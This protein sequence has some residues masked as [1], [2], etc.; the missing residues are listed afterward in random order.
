MEKLITKFE[1]INFYKNKLKPNTKLLVNLQLCKAIVEKYKGSDGSIFF[2]QDLEDDDTPI[3]QHDLLLITDQDLLNKNNLKII[4][5]F[6]GATLIF[7][8]KNK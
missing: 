8:A 3:N 6:V 2:L 4:E 7:C 1:D 5:E